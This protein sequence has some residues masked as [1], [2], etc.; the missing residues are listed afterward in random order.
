M[1]RKRRRLN[2]K[3]PPHVLVAN[4]FFVP[5]FPARL[6]EDEDKEGRVILEQS[7]IRALNSRLLNESMGIR[8]RKRAS[9]V[10]DCDSKSHR[11]R[12][13]FL[14]SKT[15]PRGPRHDQSRDNGEFIRWRRPAAL[16][17]KRP[18]A[19]SLR[20]VR[21]PLNRQTWKL[22]D[23]PTN[24]VIRSAEGVDRAGW[25]SKSPVDMDADQGSIFGCRLIPYTF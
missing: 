3:E 19:G 5:S 23:L 11:A 9:C 18:L 10:G 14:S 21:L 12:R 25:H 6:R 8:A 16:R 2:Q 4:P 24:P 7:H 13:L 15:W 1:F 20:V 22:T 17:Q